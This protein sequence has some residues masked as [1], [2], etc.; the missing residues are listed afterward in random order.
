VATTA[1]PTAQ[2]PPQAPAGVTSGARPSEFP[3]SAA[4]PSPQA[5]AGVT[6]GAR[7]SESPGSGAAGP[8][9]AST[10]PSGAASA[11]APA[12]ASA[13]AG[14]FATLIGKARAFEH[15][16][17]LT[18][19]YHAAHAA[20]RLQPRSSEV[21]AILAQLALDQGNADKAA[22]LAKRARYLD[23]RNADAYLVLG[24]VEQARSHPASA[25]A[26]FK[27][28]LALA[29]SGER[30]VEVRAVLRSSR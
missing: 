8:A 18:P 12:A 6:S 30:A 16:G 28:Y 27:K 11:A 17:A 21:F 19:A 10:L 9:V 13:S 1:P 15:R 3:G 24:T 25:R 29:P 20:Q 26:Y 7:P 23:A 14:E 4:A 5:P 2:P 22:G